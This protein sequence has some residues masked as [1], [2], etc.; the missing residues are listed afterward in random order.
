MNDGWIRLLGVILA[1]NE[2]EFKR[3][4]YPDGKYCP[5]GKSLMWERISRPEKKK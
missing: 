3:T 1:R 4:Y 2:E 5:K